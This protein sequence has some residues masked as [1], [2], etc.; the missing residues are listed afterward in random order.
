M[1]AAGSDFAH[2][3]IAGGPKLSP[4]AGMSS[5]RTVRDMTFRNACVSLAAVA[6]L[7]LQAGCADTDP[8]EPGVEKPV[9]AGVV[10]GD[11]KTRREYTD[12]VE[13]ANKRNA[14]RG[15]QGD[16][17]YVKPAVGPAQ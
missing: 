14:E 17:R 15:T 5:P 6:A 4:L 8:E 10:T 1:E 13:A 9:V 3:K 7:A 11:I 16:W 2:G 12:A